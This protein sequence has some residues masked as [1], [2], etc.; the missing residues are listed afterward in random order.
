[1]KDSLNSVKRARN[2][3]M[4]DECETC[5]CLLFDPEEEDVIDSIC[6]ECIAGFESAI[7]DAETRIYDD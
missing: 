5:G 4:T 1:M 2:F 3:S 7:W 6:E